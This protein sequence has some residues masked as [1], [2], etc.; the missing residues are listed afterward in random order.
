MWYGE[1]TY[2]LSCGERWED[3]ER[4]ERPFRRGWREESLRCARELSAAAMPR[5][6][7]LAASRAYVAQYL[8][9]S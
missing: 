9:A 2:C 1:T 8:A 6:D 4:S 7:F 5:K 3:G